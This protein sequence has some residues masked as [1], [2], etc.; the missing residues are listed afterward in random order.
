MDIK[1]P[2]EIC[3]VNSSKGSI[4]VEACIS[5]PVFLCFF[6]VLAFFMRF[7]VINITLNHAVNESA[8]Q[9]AASAYPIKFLNELEDELAEENPDYKVPALSEEMQR[10]RDTV[11]SSI[12]DS[13]GSYLK[14]LL[15]GILTG[16]INNNEIKG[17]FTDVAGNL[18]NNTP[19]I[20]EDVGS[21][22]GKYL[23][24]Q[25]SQQYFEAKARAKY[26][27]AGYLMQKFLQ[28]SG[29]DNSRLEYLLVMLPQS[30]TEAEMRNTDPGYLEV[31]NQIGFIPD[32]EDV[33]ISVQY[34]T[35]IPLPF[36][37]QK[38]IQIRKTAVEQAWMNGSSGVYAM[39]PQSEQ[40]D[41]D[42]SD[43]ENSVEES[44]KKL[45]ESTVYITRT[46]SRYHKDGC[47]HLK[48]SKIPIK[49]SEAKNKGM[50]ACKMCFEG[51]KIENVRYRRNN[52]K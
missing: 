36:F 24:Q 38:E 20:A 18:N 39:D 6:L 5:L 41:N 22:I 11:L 4:T 13:A 12:K 47:M 40:K 17:I 10:I 52:L 33:V 48:R 51:F 21:G 46:G 49:L 3:N 37:G 8:K 31:S 32:K 28:G 35:S 19:G 42:T 50:S 45:K 23:A 30:D 16:N 26:A 2:Y 44:Y 9:L 43:S 14:G 34:K 7:A 1:R 29:I 27:A 25:Y 15:P